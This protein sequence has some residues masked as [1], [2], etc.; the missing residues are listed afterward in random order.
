M[1]EEWEEEDEEDAIKNAP[2][3]GASAGMAAIT[4]AVDEESNEEDENGYC[5]INELAQVSS[6]ILFALR[7]C[8]F[9]Q[10]QSKSLDPQCKLNHL[11]LLGMQARW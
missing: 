6:A 7:E 4:C 11:V 10:I 1:E 9:S 2:A 3:S 5:K 8:L